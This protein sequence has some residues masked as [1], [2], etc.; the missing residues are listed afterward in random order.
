M[1]GA[2]NS[3][4]GRSARAPFKALCLG[5]SLCNAVSVNEFAAMRGNDSFGQSLW[6]HIRIYNAE[7]IGEVAGRAVGSR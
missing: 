1:R 3:L 5:G 2:G 7:S 4:G 6:N